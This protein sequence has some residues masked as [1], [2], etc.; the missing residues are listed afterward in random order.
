MIEQGISHDEYI[1]DPDECQNC[2]EISKCPF[3][4]ILKKLTGSTDID[5]VLSEIRAA[6]NASGVCNS[7]D[8]LKSAIT[9]AQEYYLSLLSR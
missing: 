2:G 9:S 7:P 4:P 8:A 5:Y 6:Q 1:R 3:L